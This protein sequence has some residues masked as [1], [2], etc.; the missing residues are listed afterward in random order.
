M[1]TNRSEDNILESYGEDLPFHLGIDLSARNIEAIYEIK[2]FLLEHG[3]VKK[4]FEL[5]KWI[6]ARP[7]EL[8]H[9]II[10]GRSSKPEFKPAELVA[11]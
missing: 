2:Q 7:L 4:D 1:E 10:S 3:Y 11:V 5:E 8:A 9:K 6:D